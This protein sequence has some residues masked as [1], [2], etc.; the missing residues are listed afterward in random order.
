VEYAIAFMPSSC[1]FKKGHRMQLIIRNQDDLLSRLGIW[2]V[3]ML[4]HMQTVKYDI[5]FG[6]SYLLLPV[7]PQEKK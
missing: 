3:Y 2:G 4:P 5:H 7:I 1:L 6:R